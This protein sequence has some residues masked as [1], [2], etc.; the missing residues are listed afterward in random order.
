MQFS[1]SIASLVGELESA[2]HNVLRVEYR[3]ALGRGLPREFDVTIEAIMS[4][5]SS[6]NDAVAKLIVR[7]SCL[8]E[9]ESKR[10]QATVTLDRHYGELLYLRQ[11]GPPV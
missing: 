4:N 2:G 9:L 3:R 1:T 8:Q 6:Y 7:E 11:G 5:D 10:D